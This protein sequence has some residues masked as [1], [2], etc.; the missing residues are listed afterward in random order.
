MWNFESSDLP[1]NVELC[2]ANFWVMLVEPVGLW[3]LD[4]CFQYHISMFSQIGIVVQFFLGN[5]HY[6]TNARM[7][8]FPADRWRKLC[9]MY[10]WI[11]I[12]KNIAPD[13][14]CN[15][16]AVLNTKWCMN[17]PFRHFAREDLAFPRRRLQCPPCQAL[18]LG[19]SRPTLAVEES[20]CWRRLHIL[21]HI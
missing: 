11:R 13:M 14:E 1:I 18:L 15:H 19:T 7:E 9:L 3:I 21:G 4:T 2:S 20:A 17:S 8:R 12:V 16:V 10:L 6:L 5:W